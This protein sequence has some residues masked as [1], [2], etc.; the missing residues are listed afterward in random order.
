MII[1]KLM[2]LYN[3]FFI[4]KAIWIKLISCYYKNSLTS[5]FKIE[6][7]YK[8]LA[9]NITSYIFAIILRSILKIIMPI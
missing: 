5:H 4:L 9:K 7:T 6:K 1:K 3:L 2:G 8:F